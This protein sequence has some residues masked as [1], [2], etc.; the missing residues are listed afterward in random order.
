MN[1]TDKFDQYLENKLSK[2]ERTKFEIELREQDELNELYNA[3]SQINRMLKKELY[4][5]ILN[6]NEPLPEELSTSQRLEIE[7]DIIRFHKGGKSEYFESLLSDDEKINS[8]AN[9]KNSKESAKEA[10]FIKV[11]KG[12]TQ[13][14]SE[15]GNRKIR[16][17]LGI[18]AAVAISIFAGKHI[19]ESFFSDRK[20]L[21]PKQIF[22]AFY[23]PIADKELKS[24]D[25]ESQSLKPYPDKP[26]DAYIRSSLIDANQKNISKIEFELSLL[27][28]GLI[29]M[30]RNDFQEAEK[31]FKQIRLLENPNKLNSANFYLS[32]L[33]LSEGEIN[34]ANL[35]LEELS[36]I[37]N[38]YQKKARKILRSL[39][40]E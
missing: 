19:I 22:I 13:G 16:P 27:F 6:I 36:I 38:P 28:Q 20:N 23:N 15:K 1:I 34:E 30:E 8:S 37:K 32:L 31:C 4:S 35:L 40:Q 3:Y 26:K 5:P 17:Y 25:F 2:S 11:L 21:S 39:K 18:A 12:I 33:Y 14:T 10:R 9:A 29:S 7:K 24:F